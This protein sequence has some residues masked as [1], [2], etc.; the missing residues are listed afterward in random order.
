MS[1]PLTVAMC[2]PSGDQTTWGKAANAD[3]NSIKVLV[4]YPQFIIRI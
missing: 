3:S 1:P 2:V 4:D